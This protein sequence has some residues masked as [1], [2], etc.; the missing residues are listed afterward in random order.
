LDNLTSVLKEPLAYGGIAGML[1]EW[2]I[3]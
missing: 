3:F 2:E 1:G